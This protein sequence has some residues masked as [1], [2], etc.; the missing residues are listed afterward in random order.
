MRKEDKQSGGKREGAGRKPNSV[1]ALPNLRT[2]SARVTPEM[3]EF[4]KR[5]G[6]AKFLRTLIESAMRD[7][8]NTKQ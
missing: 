5:S 4:V 6:G 7:K 3:Q 2:I 8:E 1:K